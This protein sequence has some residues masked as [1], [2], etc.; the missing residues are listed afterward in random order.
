MGTAEVSLG[1][2]VKELRRAE[3][4]L[5]WLHKVGYDI[6]M[7]TVLDIGCGAGGAL[8]ACRLAG[9]E[10]VVGVDVDSRSDTVTWRFNIPVFRTIPPHSHW[11]RIWCSHLIEHVLDP[12]G[13]LH[14][15]SGHL[16]PVRWSYIYLETPEWGPK[17]EIKLPHPFTFSQAAIHLLAKQAGLTVAAIEPGLRAVLKREK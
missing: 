17:A 10:S 5:E 15:L 1:Q 12:V 3:A 11:E 13:F 8:I 7:S 6:G 9:A 4:A 14:V 2:L 16:R